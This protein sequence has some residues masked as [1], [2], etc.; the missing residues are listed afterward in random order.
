MSPTIEQLRALNDSV[1]DLTD[2]CIERF[3]AGRWVAERELQV[4]ENLS[5]AIGQSLVE[6]RSLTD[7]MELADRLDARR[8]GELIL[9]TVFDETLAMPAWRVLSDLLALGEP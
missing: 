4:L 2:H 6:W 5:K 1:A 3:E 9:E 7:R 8:A